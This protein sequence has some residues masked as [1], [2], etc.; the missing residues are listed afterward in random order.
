M[1]YTTF[2]VKSYILLSY[3]T[4]AGVFYGLACIGLAGVAS[5]MGGLLQV[6]LTIKRQALHIQHMYMAC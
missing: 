6:M 4:G 3:I 2:V 5:L 1:L